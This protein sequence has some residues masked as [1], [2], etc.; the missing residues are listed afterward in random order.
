MLGR[1]RSLYAISPSLE[2]RIKAVREGVPATT[3]C[4]EC[5]GE[6]TKKKDTEEEPPCTDPEDEADANDCDCE[7]SANA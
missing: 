5:G 2:A 7:R 1:S 4:A 3:G 6:A